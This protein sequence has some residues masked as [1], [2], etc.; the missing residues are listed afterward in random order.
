MMLKK[1]L[2]QCQRQSPGSSESYKTPTEVTLSSKSKSIAIQNLHYASDVL[3]CTSVSLHIKIKSEVS[4]SGT[5]QNYKS[6]RQ[7]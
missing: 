6:H 3:C 5:E 2:H 7:L 4:A 1:P